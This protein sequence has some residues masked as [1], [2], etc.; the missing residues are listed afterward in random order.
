MG[1]DVVPRIDRTLVA[2]VV[3]EDPVGV[4]LVDVTRQCVGADA[5]LTILGSPDEESG[6]R[7]V[8]AP[9]LDFPLGGLPRSLN[10]DIDSRDLR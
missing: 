6:A 2:G 7:V 9:G 10:L 4:V 5:G 1:E 8:N 3:D